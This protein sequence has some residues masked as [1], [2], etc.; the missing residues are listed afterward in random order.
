M[1]IHEVPDS[2]ELNDSLEKVLAVLDNEN[3][4][5]RPKGSN[6]KPGGLILLDSV[7]TIIVPDLHARTGY[8]KTLLSWAPPG[9]TYTVYQ[10]LSSGKLQ[11]VCVGDGFHA[12]ARAVQRW[13][14]AFEE[15]INEYKNHKFIDA[16]MRESLA[17]MMSVMELKAAFPNNFHFLK[18]NHENIANEESSD[19]R[20]F[21]KFVHEGSMVKSWFNKFIEN[22]TFQNYY[23]FEKKLPVFAVGNRFCISHAEP[24]KYYQKKEIINALIQREIVFDL[25]WTGNDEAEDGSVKKYL[26]EYFPGDN[27]S[28]I[29]GGHRPVA[30]IYQSRSDGRYLQIH[31]PNKYIAVYISNMQNFSPETNILV[32]PIKAEV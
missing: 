19:N 8:L 16:E 22:E 2:G 31:N 32:L 5:I 27:G 13:K 17:V 12:E 26:E 11:V 6:G 18:G 30:D 4:K 14:G 24:R 7:P 3:T 29:F 23:R 10:G 20:P 9:E 15:Y 28:I 25:T 21:R 1:N